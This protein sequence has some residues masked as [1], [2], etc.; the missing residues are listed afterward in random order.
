[1]FSGVSVFCQAHIL[2][3]SPCLDHHHSCLYR[4]RWSSPFH[5]VFS[6]LL[7]VIECYCHNIVRLW[8]TSTFL[9]SQ[10]GGNLLEGE[11][12]RLPW[13][14]L[15]FTLSTGAAGLKPFFLQSGNIFLTN[16]LGNITRSQSSEMQWLSPN[17]KLW[18]T[19]SL[20]HW[21]TGVGA[22]RCYCI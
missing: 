18:M 20:T 22:R 19:D 2:P 9:Y 6:W 3:S 21:L 15:G 5:L 11:W 10:K 7:C 16:L 8:Y 14:S 1:M 12:S 13:P 4:C 17:L